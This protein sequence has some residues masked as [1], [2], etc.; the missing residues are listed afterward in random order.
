MTTRAANGNGKYVTQEQFSTFA[1]HTDQRFNTQAQMLEQISRK[2]DETTKPNTANWIAAGGVIVVIAGMAATLTFTQI[3]GA[4]QLHAARD[5]A[6]EQKINFLA[7]GSNRFS[8]E[9]FKYERGVMDERFDEGRD[10]VEKLREYDRDTAIRVAKMEER[11]RMIDLELAYRKQWMEETNEL[12][13]Q[14][15]A[16]LQERSKNQD[17]L[18]EEFRALFGGRT[19]VEQEQ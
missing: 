16:Q 1:T 18:L 8:R 9:D 15:E 19:R 11:A 4:S 5:D 7:S 12:S 10:R 2:I 14:L 13:I 17:R 3:Q 6:L